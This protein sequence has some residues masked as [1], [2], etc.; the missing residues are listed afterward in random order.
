MMRRLTLAA[1]LFCVAVGLAT[2]NGLD[3]S[4]N[5]DGSFDVRFELD[6]EYR[7]NLY[8]GFTAE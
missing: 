4:P 1:I 6:W 8:S 7:G 3:I 5:P 2:A